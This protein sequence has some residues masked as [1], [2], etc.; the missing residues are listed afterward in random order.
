MDK[1]RKK[2]I[3]NQVAMGIRY[4]LIQSSNY[5]SVDVVDE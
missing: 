3:G 5:D 1:K 4:D 2:E